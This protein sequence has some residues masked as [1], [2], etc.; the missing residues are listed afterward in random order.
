MY[1]M[2]E[3][4]LSDVEA[5]AAFRDGSQEQAS[6]TMRPSVMR[7]IWARQYWFEKNSFRWWSL[8]AAADICCAT[9]ACR[10]WQS[11]A[12]VLWSKWTGCAN[13]QSNQLQECARTHG[14]QTA[15]LLSAWKC[16]CVLRCKQEVANFALSNGLV[17]FTVRACHVAIDSSAYSSMAQSLQMS[18]A[19]CS[20]LSRPAAEPLG[21][22][23]G[24]S[25]ALPRQTALRCGSSASQLSKSL[26]AVSTRWMRQPSALA[27]LAGAPGAPSRHGFQGCF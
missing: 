14:M 11:C 12:Q 15:N 6:A 8:V 19:C 7:T 2:H 21:R 23:G 27:T 13:V 16:K 18:S 4:T 1:R 3:C 25:R 9:Q 22:H 17:H 5:S 10:K 26:A 20:G 24:L